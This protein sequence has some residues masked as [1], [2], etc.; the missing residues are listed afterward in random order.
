ML[1]LQGV[2]INLFADVTTAR[3]DDAC[4]RQNHKKRKPEHLEIAKD[5][6]HH[7]LFNTIDNQS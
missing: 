4:V 3:I 6:Q 1:T 5:Q 7:I 2:K